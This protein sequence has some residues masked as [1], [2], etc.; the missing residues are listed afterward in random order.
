M[1]RG[2]L[3]VIGNFDICLKVVRDVA[4]RDPVADSAGQQRQSR[5]YRGPEDRCVR[6]LRSA[7]RCAD[8]SFSAGRQRRQHH[9][10]LGRIQANTKAR[11]VESLAEDDGVSGGGVGPDRA[12]AIRSTIRIPSRPRS[13]SAIRR[14]GSRRR[15]RAR[16][17]GR[18][19]RHGHRRRD[20]RRVP[21]DCGTWNFRRAGLGGF[22]GGRAQVRRDRRTAGRARW[23]S[24]RS[25]AMDSR[26]P[27]LR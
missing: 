27:T 16:R 4:E 5:S 14:A 9:R 6:D 20:S 10:L 13:R 7:W 12:S 17:I 23:W 15:G 26:I 2:V 24:A 18:H 11:A 19:H 21:A 22:G 8:P 1:A 25:P 3:E